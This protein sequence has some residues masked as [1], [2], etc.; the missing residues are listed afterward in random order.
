MAANLETILLQVNVRYSRRE[1]QQLLIC[2]HTLTIIFVELNH[3]EGESQMIK[4]SLPLAT[5]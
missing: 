4:Y 5:A 2:I 3:V 1:L